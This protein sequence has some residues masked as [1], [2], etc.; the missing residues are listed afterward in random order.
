MRSPSSRSPSVV[1]RSIGLATL[2]EA[3]EI[4]PA[5]SITC[6]RMLEEGHVLA[7]SPGGVRE[8]LFSDHHYQLIWKE[9]KGFARVAL[10]AKTVGFVTSPSPSIHRVSLADHPDVHEELSRSDSR[11]EF[12]SSYVF[13]SFFS[14]SH[15][16]RLPCRFFT[17]HLREN[18]VASRPDLRHFS[19]QNDVSAFIFSSQSVQQSS[20]LARISVDPFHTILRSLRINLLNK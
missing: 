9:R 12:R 19:C 7:I 3:L 20:L 13:V 5:T 6:Q 14:L 18:S 17:I 8:A 15:M 11:D 16:T 2:L 4:Q 1:T 10:A